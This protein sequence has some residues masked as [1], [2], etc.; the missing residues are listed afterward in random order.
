MKYLFNL[1]ILYNIVVYTDL[2][3]FLGVYPLV[4]WKIGPNTTY[5]VE[6]SVHEI[7]TNIKWAK[8][9]GSH[10]ILDYKFSSYSILWNSHRN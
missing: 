3:N 8:K 7:G 2:E 4:G 6:S 5:V 1:N 10:L 9:F